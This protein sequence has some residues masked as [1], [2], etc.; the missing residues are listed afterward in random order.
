MVILNKLAIM[1][2]ES[3]SFTRQ[4]VLLFIKINYIFVI[5]QG[6]NLK[7]VMEFGIVQYVIMILAPTIFKI[8]E[9]YR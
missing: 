5:K 7:L 4:E 1:V 6:K 9:V 8:K 3:I 2:K